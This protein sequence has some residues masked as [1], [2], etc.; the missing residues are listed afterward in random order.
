MREKWKKIEEEKKRS[1]TLFIEQATT[2]LWAAAAAT[3][4]Q[5][6]KKKNI[7]QNEFEIIIIMVLIII[8]VCMSNWSPNVPWVTAQCTTSKTIVTQRLPSSSSAMGYQF[9]LCLATPHASTQNE[10]CVVVDNFCW[11]SLSSLPSCLLFF[12]LPVIDCCSPTYSKSN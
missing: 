12:L 1:E 5:R 4:P 7:Q 8:V 2:K 9:K 6:A 11:C 10:Q 3:V